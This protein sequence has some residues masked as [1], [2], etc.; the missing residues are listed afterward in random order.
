MVAKAKQPKVQKPVE[1]KAAC[2]D[3]IEESQ[4]PNKKMSPARKRFLRK[5]R[6]LARINK[7]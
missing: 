1:T 4:K 3:A 7:K 2:K 5:K 6:H